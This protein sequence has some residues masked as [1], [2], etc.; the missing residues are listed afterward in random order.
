MPIL[1]I[2]IVQP[3]ADIPAGLAQAVADAAGAV[4]QSHPQGTWVTVDA[5]PGTR[6]AENGG[7]KDLPVFVDVLVGQWPEPSVMRSQAS[8]IAAAVAQACARPVDNVHVIFAPAA[9]GRIAFGGKLG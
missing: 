5:L 9:K 3:E 8:E 2:R 4:F 7:A 1:N 6:Y